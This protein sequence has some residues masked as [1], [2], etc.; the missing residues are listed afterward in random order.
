[1]RL[2]HDRVIPF[3]LIVLLG[4]LIGLSATAAPDDDSDVLRP[5]VRRLSSGRVAILVPEG[6]IQCIPPRTGTGVAGPILAVQGPDG[7]WRGSGWIEGETKVLEVRGWRLGSD[8]L[9]TYIFEGGGHAEV[10]FSV[11]AAADHIRIVETCEG[12]TNT[13]V[14][15]F[16]KDFAADRVLAKPTELD[17]WTGIRRVRSMGEVR[18]GRIAVWSQFGR[19]SDLNDA[20]GVFGGKAENDFVGFMRIH[21]D[22]WTRPADNYLSLWGR[23]GTLRLE[24]RWRAGQREWLLVLTERGG[25]DADAARQRLRQLEREWV[26]TRE[27]WILDWNEPLPLQD[28]SLSRADA[29][30]KE[31][32]LSDLDRLSEILDEEGFLA[33]PR[34]REYMPDLLVFGR[35]REAG[36]FSEEEDRAA[37]RTIA[38][39]AYNCMRREIF[40]WERAPRRSRHPESLLPLLEEVPSPTFNAERY[41]VVGAVGLL[42]RRHPQSDAWLQ[43]FIG[44]FQSQMRLSVSEGGCWEDGYSGACLALKVLTPAMMGIRQERGIDLFR[45]RRYRSMWEFFLF[46]AT[47]PLNSQGRQ[48]TIPAIGREVPSH[49][50]VRDLM[51]LGAVGFQ[52][53]EPVVGGRLLWMHREMGGEAREDPGRLLN[54]LSPSGW[55]EGGQGVTLGLPTKLYSLPV[56]MGSRLFA[57]WGAVLRG[58]D[59]IGSETCLIL[60]SGQAIESGYKDEGSLHLY[61]QNTQL[62]CEAGRGGDGAW[63]GRARG[64]SRVAFVDFEPASRKVPQSSLSGGTTSDTIVSL[65]GIDYCRMQVGVTAA[66]IPNPV[67]PYTMS[68]A[69]KPLGS[70]F[71]QMR[72][73]LVVDPAYYILYDD[74]DGHHNTEFWLHSRADSW[75]RKSFGFSGSLSSFMA[76]D[77]HLIA[78][79]D[80]Q[81]RMGTA[82]STVGVTNFLAIESAGKGYQVILHPRLKDE[83]GLEKDEVSPGVFRIRSRSGVSWVVPRYPK[84][85]YRNRLRGIEL[86]GE[87]VAVRKSDAGWVAA[88]VKGQRVK[89]PGLSI[90]ASIPISVI[91]NRNGE[92]TG[93]VSKHE[94]DAM[95][96]LE[97]RGLRRKLLS[98]EG[99]PPTPIEKGM[100]EFHLPP[101]AES[102]S[103][104]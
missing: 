90:E 54:A 22:A 3:S 95:V 58:R 34:L 43:H 1:M 23:E 20:M 91:R 46:T 53:S 104:K 18:Q 30:D 41:A 49:S 75:E 83:P 96:R 89:I 40:P 9:V 93:S 69:E 61:A 67:S 26:W 63:R 2:L 70:V 97:G 45:D 15:S 31:L 102:F 52:D 59:S 62:V 12:C 101:E 73:V 10:R 35:L 6:R 21:A 84:G 47:P 85:Y 65:P 99:I 100:V 14:L 94:A 13:W 11:P 28:P 57:G 81:A 77:L 37:R 24:G 44:Q 38:A 4:L 60:R 98:V 78:P 29:R 74:I 71:N 56:E 92:L 19:L 17:G 55:G 42:F 5:T 7:V 103:V 27:G 39:L 8:H 64:Y 48:R 88:I 80:G 25:R 51:L 86:E 72:S 76:V 68:M 50:E 33:P 36:A 87:I 16:A 82:E 32:V 66:E 79:R